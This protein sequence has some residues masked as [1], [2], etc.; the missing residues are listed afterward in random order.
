MKKELSFF[1]MLVLS[2]LT[3][4]TQA[5]ATRFDTG[6]KEFRQP[7]G[8]IF[9]GRMW[10]DEYDYT[11]QTKDGYP[12]D[13]NFNNGYYYFAH[14]ERDGIYQL[15]NLRVGIDAPINIPKNLS[16]HVTLRSR[17]GKQGLDP[18]GLNKAAVATWTLKVIMVEFQDIRGNANANWSRGDFSNMLFSSNYYKSPSVQSPSSEDV[19]GSLRD[20]YDAM[21]NGNMIITGQILNG[22]LPGGDKPNWI[23]LSQNKSYY[24]NNSVYFLY[25]EAIDSA[26]AR[27][28][29]TTTNSTTKLVILYAGNFYLASL[30][31]QNLGDSYIMFER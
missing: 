27:G 13:K 2:S 4:T 12:F 25:T 11:F 8:V 22:P 31:P 14:S 19:Y 24:R 1:V 20:Y 18:S 3:L 30:T 16:A 17:L 9:I 15:S 29:N 23:R 7:N 10:G 26:N 28:Y 5:W 6:W 21:S